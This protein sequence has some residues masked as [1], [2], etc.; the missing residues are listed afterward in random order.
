LSGNVSD[1]VRHLFAQYGYIT[2]ELVVEAATPEDHPLHPHFEWDDG[3]AAHKFRLSQA[4]GLIRR[5]DRITVSSPDTEPAE[6][7]VREFIRFTAHVDESGETHANDA[8]LSVDQVGSNPVLK[9]AFLLQMRRDWMTLRR[10]YQN[11]QEFW[12]MIAGEDS[13]EAA[14][15]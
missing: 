1:N 2:P 6:S 5:V 13:G 7:T 11:Y 4:G 15:G 9:N 14:T 12:D 8:Y 3:E 10:K